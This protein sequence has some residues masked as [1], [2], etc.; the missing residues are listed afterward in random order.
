MLAITFD[1]ASASMTLL[2]TI[3]GVTG[4]PRLEPSSAYSSTELLLRLCLWV[5]TR[6]CHRFRI[7]RRCRFTKRRSEMVFSSLEV[8]KKP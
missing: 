6:F 8:I 4:V 3:P 2:A 1:E 7:L 5:L